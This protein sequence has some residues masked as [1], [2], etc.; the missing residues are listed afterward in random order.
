MFFG[1]EISRATSLDAQE[2][3]VGVG[4]VVGAANGF[5]VLRAYSGAALECEGGEASLDWH[6]K[7]V[8]ATVLL[9]HVTI[10]LVQFVITAANVA[11]L[12]TVQ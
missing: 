8:L 5:V 2:A 11:W 1:D 6:N 4:F 9:S 12:L 7:Y 10:R 3:L